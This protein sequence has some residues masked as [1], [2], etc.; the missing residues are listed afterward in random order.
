MTRKMHE[1][2]LTTLAIVLAGSAL[3]VKVSHD[4]A[5]EGTGDQVALAAMM[6]GSDGGVL[7]PPTV[8]RG[9]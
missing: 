6:G 4:L 5:V 1:V 3:A 7:L 2:Y 8:L 9:H